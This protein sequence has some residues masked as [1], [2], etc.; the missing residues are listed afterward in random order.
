[1]DYNVRLNESV[2]DYE[3]RKYVRENESVMDFE[4]RLRMRLRFSAINT[5]GRYDNEAI[6]GHVYLRQQLLGFTG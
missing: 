4:K 3:K 1:M 2:M 5:K 6:R